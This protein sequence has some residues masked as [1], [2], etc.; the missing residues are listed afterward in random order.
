[1]TREALEK[2]LRRRGVKSIFGRALSRCTKEELE[3]ALRVHTE[4]KPFP[5]LSFSQINTYQR[6]P[7]Q[8]YYRYVRGLKIPPSGAVVVG[9]ATHEAIAYDLTNYMNSRLHE[10]I[11]VIEDVYASVF[12]EYE[13]GAD[14]REEKPEEAF[15]GGLNALKLYFQDY[16]PLV[17]PESIEDEFEITLDGLGCCIKGVIDLVDAHENAVIEHKTSKRRFDNSRLKSSQLSLYAFAK[18]RSKIGINVLVRTQ[19]PKIQIMRDNISE[20]RIYRAL[21]DIYLIAEAINKLS[22]P[23]AQHDSWVCSEK[24][25]GYYEICH[26]EMYEEVKSFITENEFKVLEKA[27]KEGGDGNSKAE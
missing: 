17:V 1:M 11:D 16:I 21:S 8:F 18:K 13:S 5:H 26:A 9:K 3:Y 6:C 2:E 15:K 10:P 14:W 27:I 12:Q 24:W 25:C 20:E 22:F 7:R 19:T 23:P 4:G